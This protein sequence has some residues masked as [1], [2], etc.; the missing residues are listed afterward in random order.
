[1]IEFHPKKSKYSLCTYKQQ[2]WIDTIIDPV[3]DLFNQPYS[4][5]KHDEEN[6]NMIGECIG[7]RLVNKLQRHR[8]GAFFT[9]PNWNWE[10]NKAPL[11]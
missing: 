11:S 9:K 4:V 3:I 5:S 8:C 6:K 2:T 1:M 7:C 10:Y